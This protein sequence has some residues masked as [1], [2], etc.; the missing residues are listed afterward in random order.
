MET[1]QI[2]I[3]QFFA[4]HPPFDS[5][6]EEVINNLAMQVEV[7]YYRA[8]VDVL[9]FAETINDLYVIRSGAV[10]TYRRTGELYNRLDEGGIFGHVGLLMNQRVRFPVKTIEDTLLY[11]IP[12][13]VFRE[14]MDKYEQFADY[15]ETEHQSPLRKIISDQRAGN[16]LTSVKVKNLL[17]RDLITVPMNT[18]VRDA[19]IT[20]T[21]KAVSSLLVVDPC[22]DREDGYSFNLQG[23]ITDRDLRERVLAKGLPMDTPVSAIISKDLI[24]IDDSSYVFEAMLT[25]LRFNVH[26]L[27]V[28]QRDHPVGVLALS[29]IVQHESQSSILLVRSIFSQSTLDELGQLAQQQSAAFV[30]M[31][32]EDANSHMIGS[33]MS[34]IGR[35]FKQRLLEMAETQLGHPPIPYCFLALGSM[36]RDEQ[37][38]HTDQDNALILDDRYDE[39]RH[40]AYFEQLAKFV[41]DGLAVCGYRYCDGAIMATNPMWRMTQSA[42]KAR[43]NDWIENPR[44]EALLH[45]SIF[46]DLDGVWGQ[47]HW[48]RMLQKFVATKT[49]GN[50]KF[51]A[52]M[53]RNALNRKPPLGFF[54]GFVLEKDGEHKNSINL[55]RRGTAPLTDVIRVHALGI[56]STSVNSFK[57]LEDIMAAEILPQGKGR[58]LSDALEYI[59]MVRIR[60]QAKQIEQGGV[61]DNN[62]HPEQLSSF[63]R[64][65]LKEAF[66]V[67]SNA[68]NF[69]KYRYNS[70]LALQ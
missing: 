38:I 7:A 54:K 43:F 70:N 31:V 36:A 44:P 13:P 64:R 67:V 66:Q 46:F 4:N 28:I 15:F 58:D 49:Q 35:S 53:A 39:S 26:H 37:L 14:Y 1:E 60:H 25:M 29:D 16:D 21:D 55:K 59:S 68:Q 65:N 24:T 63:E 52:Y 17:A 10:E 8:D 61:P 42:W 2:E 6:S 30:R 32:K 22:Q 9:N 40:G 20:M 69:L 19:A 50:K 47:T 5:L 57:R 51:L 3:A 12:A 27:P 41:S 34:V 23:I 48:A 18:S 45:S 33:A 56:G 11:C 62:V